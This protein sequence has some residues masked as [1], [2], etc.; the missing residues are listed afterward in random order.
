MTQNINNGVRVIGFDLDGVIVDHS[1]L[2][3]KLASLL[4]FDISLAETHSNIIKKIIPND[5]LKKIQENIYCKES[6]QPLIPG[7]LNILEKLKENNINFFLISRRRTGLA[8]E[9]AIKI[10]KNRGLWPKFFNEKNV[11]FV[12]SPEGKN[13]S[14]KKLEVTHYF[15]DEEDV[16]DAIKCVPNRFLFD[17]FDNFPNSHFDRV[18][19][20]KELEIKIT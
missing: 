7:T 12:E 13:E 14:A 4:G 2:K 15:D 9:M 5:D 6:S 10:M 8:R 18:K 19:N 3:K 17:Q 20:W 11:Y 1:L 16:L